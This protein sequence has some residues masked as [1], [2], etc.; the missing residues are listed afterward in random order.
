[1]AQKHL[2]IFSRFFIAC[3]VL[4]IIFFALAIY[5]QAHAPSLPTSHTAIPPTDLVN[6][7]AEVAL[8]Y[9]SAPWSEPLVATQITPYGTLKGAQIKATITSPQAYITPFVSNDQLKKLGFALDN[10]LA[11]NGAGSGIW[12]YKKVDNKFSQILLFMYQTHAT[13]DNTNEPLQFHCP[14]TMDITAFISNEY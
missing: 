2:Q 12:G 11:A 8:S 5:R 3:V 4:L 13:S 9:P 10:S 1:M 14:C 7:L 6:V